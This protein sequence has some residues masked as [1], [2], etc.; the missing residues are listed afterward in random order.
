MPVRFSA[1]LLL[2]CLSALLINVFTDGSHINLV[3]ELHICVT[4]AAEKCAAR[5]ILAVRI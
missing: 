2:M 5:E 1:S 4:D 3:V